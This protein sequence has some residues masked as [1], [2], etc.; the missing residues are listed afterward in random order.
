MQI[1][2]RAPDESQQSVVEEI[3]ATA[4]ASVPHQEYYVRQTNMGRLSY[5]QVYLCV[6]LSQEESYEA[7]EVDR[8]RSL[9]YEPLHQ[10]FPHLA[11]DLIM[12]CDRIWVERA[13]MSA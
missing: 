6:S 9:I 1:M 11:M 10:A 4:L 2:G 13:V 3:V 8:V 12:T 5:V 7:G